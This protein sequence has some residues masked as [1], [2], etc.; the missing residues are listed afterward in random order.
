MK[1]RL[2]KLV[3]IGLTFSLVFSGGNVCMAA[4][5]SSLSSVLPAAGTARVLNE[6]KSVT[7]LKAEQIKSSRGKDEAKAKAAQKSSEA[8]LASVASNIGESIVL[9][10]ETEEAQ[11]ISVETAA[12]REQTSIQTVAAEASPEPEI[13][14]VGGGSTAGMVNSA[15]SASEM[16]ALKTASGAGSE[17]GSSVLNLVDVVAAGEN[18]QEEDFT[19]L[20]I[21]Q[22]NDYVNVRDT[23]SEEGEVV[24]KL[25]NN[26][27]GDLIEIDGDWY[28]IKSGNV[29]GYVKGEYC[30]TGDE[31][32]QLAKQVGMRLAVVTTTTLYVRSEPSRDAEVIG[33]VPMEDELQVL[34]ELDGWVKVSVE[35]GDGFVSSEFVRI[36][37]DFVRAE[38]K[39]EEEARL[40]KEAAEREAARKA[41]AAAAKK[42]KKG[43]GGGSSGGGSGYSA[44]GSSTGSAVANYALQFVGNPYVYGGT[45]LTNGADCSGFVMSVY[46]NFGVSLPHSSGADRSVG[47]GV[48]SIAEA[49]PGDIICYSG[50]VGIYIGNGQIVH[51]STRATGI[52][53]SNAGYR[54]VL[55]VRRIF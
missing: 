34:D 50:H 30:V 4:G 31:A 3:S 47:Y 48:S 32:Q 25:Y 40:A 24:G 5:T 38:S 21:A 13:I 1:K 6:G 7:S 55:A 15:Q 54:S 28:K 14:T 33:M 52:K 39:A 36:Y 35:E 51:A 46:R 20:V 43:S 26:S 49:Q 2:M 27:V 10:K 17:S 45:S 37:T 18:Q 23:A 42:N 12:P 29:T 19:N 44:P 11:M 22:V 9:S 8:V 53:V 16:S 41:A